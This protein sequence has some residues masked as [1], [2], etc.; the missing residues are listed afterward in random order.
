[1]LIDQRNTFTKISPLSVIHIQKGNVK[2][3]GFIAKGNHHMKSVMA[4]TK[5]HIIK[6]FTKS[7][8]QSFQR[9]DEQKQKMVIRQRNLNI[10]YKQTILN[11][12][13]EDK[14]YLTFLIKE[15]QSRIA[16][17][18]K[19]RGRE[20]GQQIC[21]KF[22]SCFGLDEKKKITLLNFT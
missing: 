13:Q 5:L 15:F 22:L 1:M 4:I 18:K 11:T 2:E 20:R 10:K 21:Y 19:E 8:S 6:H 16:F 3:Q 7:P 12:N 9:L 17:K 14:V